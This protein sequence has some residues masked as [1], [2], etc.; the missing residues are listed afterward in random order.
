MIAPSDHV[1]R[2]QAPSNRWALARGW[3]RALSLAVAGI[4]SLLLM[5]Y[6]Y[7]LNGVPGWKMHTGL[8]VMMLGVTGL[9]MAGLGFSPRSKLLRAIFHP[10]AAWMLFALGIL[11]M[12]V[13]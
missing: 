9:Y 12:A 5:L 8:P 10:L 13:E 3:G 2:E 11:V 7:V 6:P 1:S 4:A